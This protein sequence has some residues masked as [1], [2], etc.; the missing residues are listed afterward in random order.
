MVL[1]QNTKVTFVKIPTK[2]KLQRVIVH[3][4]IILLFQLLLISFEIYLNF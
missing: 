2:Y 1:V 3:Q 4:N